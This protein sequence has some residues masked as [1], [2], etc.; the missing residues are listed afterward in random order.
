[1]SII[2]LRIRLALGFSL[3]MNHWRYEATRSYKITRGCE[4]DIEHMFK[5]ERLSGAVYHSLSYLPTAQTV[6]DDYI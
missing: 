4:K 6:T 5:A 1:M 2:Y 3:E